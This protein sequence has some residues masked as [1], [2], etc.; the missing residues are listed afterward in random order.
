MGLLA[1]VYRSGDGM[2]ATLDGL[3]S[4]F[5]SFILEGTEVLDNDCPFTTDGDDV[6]VYVEKVI[7]GE[8]VHY[9]YP[10]DY[11]YK[12]YMFGGNWLY[13]SDSRFPTRHPIRIMDRHES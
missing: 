10:R 8:K 12:H 7:S 4:K 5:N 2:D 11:K 13:T 3:S 9:A 6:L 1:H